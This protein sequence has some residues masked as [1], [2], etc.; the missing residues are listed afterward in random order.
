[1]CLE[2]ISEWKN[3]QKIDQERKTREI[4]GF[5]KFRP[6]VILQRRWAA[7][8]RMTQ[9]LPSPIEKQPF[10]CRFSPG[11]V[12]IAS[13]VLLS[14]RGPGFSAKKRVETGILA[15]RAGE[16]DSTGKTGPVT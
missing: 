14:D 15:S 4:R 5:P 11:V 9:E 2:S 10:R 7:L 1:M 13:P 6:W 12:K 3:I 16:T 8:W